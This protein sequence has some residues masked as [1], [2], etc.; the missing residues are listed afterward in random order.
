MWLVTTNDNL[1]TFRF[2]QRRGF[3]LTELRV[4]SVDK[5]RR[6]LKPSIPSVGYFGIPP[7]DELVLELEHTRL[8]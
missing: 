4:G 8:A 5:A 3:R 6:H 2:Y 1:D 7:H